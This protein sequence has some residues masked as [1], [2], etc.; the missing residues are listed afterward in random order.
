MRDYSDAGQE[1][2]TKAYA[3]GDTLAQENV[4]VILGEGHHHQ[5]E[6]AQYAAEDHQVVE[7]AL[8][9][10]PSGD[11]KEKGEPLYQPMSSVEMA[12]GDAH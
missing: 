10:E 6:Y 11:W 7:I 2:S 12:V 3:Q 5:G 8:V 1:E 4:V 9:E